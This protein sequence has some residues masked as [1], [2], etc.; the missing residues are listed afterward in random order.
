MDVDVWY[1][2]RWKPLQNFLLCDGAEIR[3]KTDS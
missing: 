2:S 1:G 3:R